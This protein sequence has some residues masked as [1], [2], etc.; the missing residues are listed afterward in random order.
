MYDEI[1]N[2]K[3]GFVIPEEHI[4]SES[5]M[6]RYHNGDETIVPV[7][8]EGLMYFAVN[9]VEWF[10]KITETAQ[11]YAEDCISEAMMALTEFVAK[12]L[13]RQYTIVG[14][15]SSVKYACLNAVKDWLREMTIAV[16]IPARSQ[17]AGYE[18]T[19]INQVKLEE[20]LKI[21]SPDSV[22]DSVWFDEFMD[23]L[24]G[25]DAEIVRMKI[26]GLSDREIGRE[27]GLH[28]ALVND[29]LRR[30]GELYEKG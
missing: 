12:N 10:L 6:V 11:P 30:L 4:P 21:S 2:T 22:F 29:R 1:Y 18:G 5:D 20:S 27:I 28:R 14:F 17:Q 13:G 24:V 19:K 7:L 15:L 23:N 25:V 26:Q 8:T 3:H 16:T 9:E